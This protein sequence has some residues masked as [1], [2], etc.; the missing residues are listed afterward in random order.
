[1]IEINITEAMI[2]S[3]KRKAKEMG[4][5]KNSIVKGDGNEAGF[6]GEE[7]ANIV[8]GGEISNTYEYDIV[9]EGITYDVKTK[10]CTSV[11]KPHY[12]CSVAD[13]NT[14]QKCDRYIFVR[15][16]FE[17]MKWGRAWVLGYCDKSEYFEKS[18]KKLKGEKDGSNGFTIRSD[19]HNLPISKL[20]E[21]LWMSPL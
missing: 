14:K 16:E 17:D 12:E 13:F 6:V 4:V 10:R 15:I 5:L 8:L 20:K 21:E 19:C 1:M 3:A 9:S 7:V 11:P 18:V 2:N